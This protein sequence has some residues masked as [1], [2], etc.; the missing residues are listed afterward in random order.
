MFFFFS[1]K[2]RDHVRLHRPE[3][4]VCDECTKELPSKFDLQNHIKDDHGSAAGVLR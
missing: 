4:V 2:V 3:K 1:Q